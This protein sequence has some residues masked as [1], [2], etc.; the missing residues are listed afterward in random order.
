MNGHDFCGGQTFRVPLFRLDRG[1]TRG[2]S[3]ESEARAYRQSINE[4]ANRLTRL[5]F[6][7]QC[8]KIPLF[9]VSSAMT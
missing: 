6:C 3:F 1:T 2:Y 9:P 8:P 5:C 4:N 7:K